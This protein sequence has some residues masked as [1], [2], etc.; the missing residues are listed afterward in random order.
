MAT[1]EEIA[2]K[3]AAML[4]GIPQPEGP[5]VEVKVAEGT[6]LQGKAGSGK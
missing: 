6:S 5:A 4:G 2:A 3:V 1:Q